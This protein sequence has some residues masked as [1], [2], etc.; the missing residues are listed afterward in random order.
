MVAVSATAAVW[1]DSTQE[2]TP[3]TQSANPAITTT[4]AQSP[5]SFDGTLTG[6][7]F[8]ARQKLAD[9]GV[10]IG[11]TLIAEGFDNFQGGI[12]TAHA[13]GATTF[14]L[15]ATFDLQKL[16][17]IAN[18]QVYVDLEDH[19]FRNPSI[20]MVGEFL[21]FDKL[22]SS[23]YLQFAE[24]WYQQSWFDGV[25]RLKIGKVD[26][27]NEFS[28]IDNGAPFISDSSQ[29]DPTILP[30]P[31]TPSSQPGANLFFT[32]ANGY[33]A[34]FGAYY[35]NQSDRFGDLVG[36]PAGAL[37]ARY[38]AFLI[39][40]TGFKWDALPGLKYAGNVKLGAWGDTGTFHRFDGTEQDG[41]GGVYAIFDQTVYQPLGE[42]ANGRGIRM[43][44]TYGGTE[45]HINP[46]DEHVGAGVTLTGPIQSRSQDILGITAQYGQISQAAMVPYPFELSME[47]FYQ[48]QLTGWAQIQ[49]DLQ[50]IIH[51]GGQFRDALVATLRCTIQF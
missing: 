23:P 7:W 34:S 41:T 1:A 40:E 6:D 9:A 19:A 51:P 36:D 38:G 17:N 4:S 14:D 13:M 11:A 45:T 10:S 46:I 24:L 3:A 5:T 29:V 18:A 32:P 12:D 31:T 33:F 42:G 49:P 44:A 22:N 37:P 39:G 43:F 35:S 21:T 27:N 15:T 2:A 48:I 28:V 20:S 26:A 8:G 25:L 50:Y 47:A 30:M 16:L